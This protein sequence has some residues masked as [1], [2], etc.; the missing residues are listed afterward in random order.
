MS[1]AGEELCEWC[2]EP[3]REH[4]IPEMKSCLADL[5]AEKEWVNDL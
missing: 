5:S 3:V 1:G 4:T 2:L